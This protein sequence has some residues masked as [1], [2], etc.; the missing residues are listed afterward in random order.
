[1]TERKALVAFMCLILLA[2]CRLFTDRGMPRPP[3]NSGEGFFVSGTKLYDANGAEFRIQGVNANHWWNTGS[4]NRESVPYI[5]A[6]GAN[7]VRLVFGPAED[8]DNPY[9]YVCSTTA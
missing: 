1:M 3:S 2:S 7:A 4:D 9:W 5:K 6:A 8:P